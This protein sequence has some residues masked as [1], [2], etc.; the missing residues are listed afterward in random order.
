MYPEQF[1]KIYC[2]SVIEHI[3]DE[4]IRFKCL[5]NMLKLLKPGGELFISFD[6][7]LSG[8][9]NNSFY[10]DRVG[11]IKLLKYFGTDPEQNITKKYVSID[12]NGSIIT[13]MCLK[14]TI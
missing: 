3:K 13:A 6:V 12:M 9:A 2:L 5:D 1:D 10:I 8:A 7:L 14:V 4:D 11:A